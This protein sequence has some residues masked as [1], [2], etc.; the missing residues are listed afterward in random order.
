[1]RFKAAALDRLT[2]NGLWSNDIISMYDADFF[3]KK[4]KKERKM[5]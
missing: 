5:R 4:K 2:C 1:M 3:E